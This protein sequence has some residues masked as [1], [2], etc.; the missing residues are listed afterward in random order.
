MDSLVYVQ[1]VVLSIDEDDQCAVCG[2]VSATTVV[3][4]V[5]E[6]EYLPQTLRHLVWCE[7]CGNE[8][9]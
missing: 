2:L 4:V 9:G 1:I 3:Y 7:N 8:S 6:Y 5:E